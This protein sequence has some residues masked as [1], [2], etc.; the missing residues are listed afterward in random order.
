[1]V[2]IHDLTE[3]HAKLDRITDSISDI[4]IKMGKLETTVSIKV[5]ALEK[6]QMCHDTQIKDVCD[7][8]NNMLI[9]ITGISTTLSILIGGVALFLKEKLFGGV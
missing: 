8:Q 7:K 6:K 3:L 4:N 1:M 9:T 2:K 5:D